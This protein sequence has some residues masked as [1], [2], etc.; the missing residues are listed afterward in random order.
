MARPLGDV[1]GDTEQANDLALWLRKVTAG[2]TVSE[3]AEKFHV[4]RSSW[5]ALRNGS[6]LI[7]EKLL[8]DIVNELI[9]D[10]QSQLRERVRKEGHRLL[11]AATEAEEQLKSS[12]PVPRAP[13]ARPTTSSD[14]EDVYRRLDDARLKQLEAM[15][16]LAGSEKRCA[17]LE[18]MV[19]LLQDQ[20]VQL[21]AERDRARAEARAEVQAE[22]ETAL[23]QS[24]ELRQRADDQLE[25]ARRANHEAQALGLAAEEQV[26]Q[27]KA[28]V[29]HAED[30]EA[31]A[32]SPVSVPAATGIVLPSMAQIADAL[33]LSQEDL[34]EQDQGIDELRT[35]L[36]VEGPESLAT[37]PDVIRIEPETTAPPTGP[38]G[39]RARRALVFPAD[40]AVVRVVHQHPADNADNPLTSPDTEPSEIPT[41]LTIALSRVSTAAEL[42]KHIN[43]LGLRAH[44]GYWS[45]ADMAAATYLGFATRKGRRL[46]KKWL[47]GKAVPTWPV[48]KPLLVAMGAGRGE[49][50]AFEGALQRA[51]LTAAVMADP[52]EVRLRRLYRLRI[53]STVATCLIVLGAT[54]GAGIALSATYSAEP[55][56]PLWKALTS[57]FATLGLTGAAVALFYR[58]HQTGKSF[59]VLAG[60]LPFYLTGYALPFIGDHDFGGRAIATAIGFL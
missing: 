4:S 10:A 56:Q 52:V 20:C 32:G 6:R 46:V 53:L 5:T 29:R 11:K 60:W 27:A 28:D 18:G 48:L 15:R 43:A 37:G 39:Q 45:H 58:I 54:M 51:S 16:M 44:G 21:R 19:S 17:R 38:D 14:L 26:S 1:K 35:G 36:G 34:E 2:E 8:N 30:T 31:Q 3:L 47:A 33:D 55:V 22:L 59:L 41:E 42:G 9:P 24:Q 12:L 57:I 40:P 50:V 7:S 13:S 25:H 49:L 23:E